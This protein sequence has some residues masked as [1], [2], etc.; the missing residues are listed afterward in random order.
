MVLL[1]IIPMKNGYISLGV[2]PTFSD[3]PILIGQVSH[4]VSGTD[5]VQAAMPEMAGSVLNVKL[6]DREVETRCETTGV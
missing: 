1:I 4:Y 5:W 2:Y 6:D 3:K